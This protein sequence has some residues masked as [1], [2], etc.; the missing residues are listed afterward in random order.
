MGEAVYFSERDA[1]T[2]ILRCLMI[3]DRLAEA[4]QA[5]KLLAE[6]EKAGDL[7]KTQVYLEQVSELS[8]ALTRLD[9][10]NFDILFL[11]LGLPGAD[12][13]EALIELK[14]KYPVLPV[15]VLSRSVDQAAAQQALNRGATDCL[16]LEQADSHRLALAVWRALEHSHL[17]VKLRA[18]Q[19]RLDWLENS[20]SE[21]VWQVRSDLHFQDVTQSIRQLTGFSVEEML[22]LTLLDLL[23]EPS[24]QIVQQAIEEKGTGSQTL[25]VEHFRKDGSLFWAEIVLLARAGQPD[26]PVFINGVT[27]DISEKHSLKERLQYLGM[28]DEMT[29]L[30]NRAYFQE[31]L[32]R[33]EFS[34]LHPISI[35]V[36][37]L[38]GAKAVNA[39]FG[40][41]A[42][43]ELFKRAAA[44]FRQVFRSEDMVARISTDEF[45]AI[46]PLTQ[47]HSAGRALQRVVNLMDQENLT[48]LSVPLHMSLRV[49][50]AETGQSLV[51]TLQAVG[52]EKFPL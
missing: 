47:A 14:Q 26:G 34:R 7:P 13:L 39:E 17:Q 6:A 16:F 42:G 50:T 23:T 15:V 1:M 9:C 49:A 38:E 27:R 2:E 40:L 37:E 45:V 4:K 30:Y 5:Q 44:I 20:I 46:M 10:E 33:L 36:A 43:D 11:E 24:R 32:A 35:M 51:T 29:G 18:D 8:D 48:H 25:E 31:E 21:A 52:P 22:Q 12:G 19:E 28:H 41:Q 3:E